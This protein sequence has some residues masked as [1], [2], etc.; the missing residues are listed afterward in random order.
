[1]LGINVA[2]TIGAYTNM[3]KL[4]MKWE[5]KKDSGTY[6]EKSDE[7]KDPTT[8][9][10]DEL[11]EQNENRDYSMEAIRNK[12]AS[13]K[14]L[15][16]EELKYLEEKDPAAYQKAKEIQDAQEGFENALKNCRTKEDV[17]HV[18]LL[19]LGAAIT[20][21]NAADHDPNIPAGQK[22]AII[23]QENAKMKA[24]EKVEKAF[25]ESGA[26]A[27]LPSEAELKEKI[28]EEQEDLKE[29][30]EGPAKRKPPKPGRKTKPPKAAPKQKA[31]PAQMIFLKI[32]NLKKIRRQITK[33]KNLR[34]PKPGQRRQKAVLQKR[35]REECR[36]LP[37]EER[38]TRIRKPFLTICRKEKKKSC[39]KR[40]RH[41]KP[42]LSKGPAVYLSQHLLQ[43]FNHNL[44]RSDTR[45][46]FIH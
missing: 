5:N 11:K 38:W 37:A 2:G 45:I 7:Q 29:K 18:K 35:R 41:C 8:R 25:V 44:Q 24:I 4:Q 9:M 30:T 36:E 39:A 33:S 42:D 31:R 19:H 17:Q 13:G 43:L 46:F 26:Y 14:K 28:K 22:L 21:V 34:L 20:A 3:M 6:T 32:K 15:T 40:H 16:F 27:Q 10:L 23:L 1:M 12:L